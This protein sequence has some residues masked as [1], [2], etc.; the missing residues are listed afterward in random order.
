MLGK[1]QRASPESRFGIVEARK[2]LRDMI[3]EN[4]IVVVSIGP[5]ESELA[6]DAYARFGKGINLAGLNMGDCFAY[7]CAKANDARLLYK[8]KNFDRTG[9]FG[10]WVITADQLPPGGKGLKIESRLNGKVMQSDNTKNM[11]FPLAETLVYL[12]QGITLEPG[13][14]VLTGTP[15]GVGHARKPPVWMRNGDVCEIEIE[16]IGI[17]RNPIE[18]DAA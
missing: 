8:G 17:L 10:P 4:E 5:A 12:T 13:D 6:L 11:M 18:L 16:G 15:S 14:I 1:T 7:A 9:S 2:Q 3:G